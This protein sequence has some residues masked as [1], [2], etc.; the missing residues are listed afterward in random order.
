M[1]VK[2]RLRELIDRGVLR[3]RGVHRGRSVHRHRSDVCVFWSEDFLMMK[4][5]MGVDRS[6]SIDRS[7]NVA[8]FMS[9]DRNRSSVDRSWRRRSVHRSRSV[10]FLGCVDRSRSVRFRSVVRFNL[11]LGSFHVFGVDGC[12]A[13]DA[14]EHNQRFLNK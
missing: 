1:D 10:A 11:G 6:W 12:Q 8:F 7:R 2:W 5:L 4:F 14:T 9:V 3:G 13:H